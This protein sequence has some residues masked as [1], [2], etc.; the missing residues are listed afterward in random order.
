MPEAC[1]CIISMRAGKS[2]LS[3]CVESNTFRFYSSQEVGF[4]FLTLPDL[5]LILTEF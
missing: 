4:S 1:H 5:T 2:I 3:F